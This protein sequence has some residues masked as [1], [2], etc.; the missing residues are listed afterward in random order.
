MFFPCSV[1]PRHWLCCG[2][3]ETEN[4][5]HFLLQPHP[6]QVLLCLLW[7]WLQIYHHSPQIFFWSIV[8]TLYCMFWIISPPVWFCLFD[9]LFLGHPEFRCIGC[10]EPW[11]L[12]LERPKDDLRFCCKL[13][14]LFVI[15]IHQRSSLNSVE[16]P[17]HRSCC[18]GFGCLRLI[19]DQIMNFFVIGSGFPF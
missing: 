13:V 9:F 1:W 14:S 19:W 3:I 4:E 6:A 15:V 11:I 17:H 5:E 18:C 16:V 8:H 12:D 2:I 7:Y 10:V